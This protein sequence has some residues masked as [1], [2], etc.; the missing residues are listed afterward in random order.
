[1]RTNERA[2]SNSTSG[3]HTHQHQH[4]EHS[5][6]GAPENLTMV[7]KWVVVYQHR[8]LGYDILM[9]N[10]QAARKWDW[11]AKFPNQRNARDGDRS[12]DVG[13]KRT[14]KRMDEFSHKAWSCV[15]PLVE[16]VFGPEDRTYY[17]RKIQVLIPCH[18]VSGGTW[19]WPIRRLCHV[20]GLCF[21]IPQGMYSDT[22]IKIFLK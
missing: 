4:R 20:H 22:L 10:C 19:N 9:Q 14:R 7:K 6:R 16:F 12:S 17:R 1:V 11:V 13:E 21:L 3:R 2:R 18:I 15:S 5:S 8:I